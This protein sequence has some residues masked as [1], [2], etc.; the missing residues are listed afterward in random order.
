[1]IWT[2]AVDILH[3]T[4][5][6]FQA[7][8]LLYG[9]RG[10]GLTWLIEAVLCLLAANRGSNCSLTRAMDG[11]IVRCGIISSC[12]SAAT[13]EIVKRFWSRVTHVRSA[14]ASARP[15]FFLP[16]SA[17]VSYMLG[18]ITINIQVV[19]ELHDKHT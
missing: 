6:Q 14:I 19:H 16:L 2:A 3:G 4:L 8:T 12:Q 5:R 9:L 18:C 15:L 11:R 13:S 10:E 1:V 17:F 7:K